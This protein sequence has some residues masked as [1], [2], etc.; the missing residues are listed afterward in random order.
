MILRRGSVWRLAISDDPK[1]R[2]TWKGFRTADYAGP[3]WV[4]DFLGNPD[5]YLFRHTE[6]LSVQ[7]GAWVGP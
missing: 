7:G 3:E 4:A 6:P 2:S 1:P 5:A